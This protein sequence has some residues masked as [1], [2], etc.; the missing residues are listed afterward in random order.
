MKKL[1]C[2]RST[3]FLYAFSAPNS[4]DF[5]K[6]LIFFGFKKALK[7]ISSW[8]M[9]KDLIVN[10]LCDDDDFSNLKIHSVIF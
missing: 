3:Q 6:S 2:D 10:Q 7:R 8:E 9:T 4:I 1:H 5:K